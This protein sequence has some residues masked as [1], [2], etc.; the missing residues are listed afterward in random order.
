VARL[1]TRD[2]LGALPSVGSR[3]VVRPRIETPDVSAGA[4]GMAGFGKSL[5]VLGANVA[6]IADQA[7]TFEAERRFQE[8]KWNEA[9][10][11]D[12]SMR[13][14]QP[15]QAQDLPDT[16]SSGYR[17]RA[18]EFFKTI[19]D[20]LK[21][22]Y[23]AK[24][25]DAERNFYGDAATFARTEQKRFSL[26]ALDEQKNRL[27]SLGSLD[28]AVRDYD[29]LLIANP[30]LS[31]I[32]KDEVRRKHLDE[33]EELNIETRLYRGDDL[34]E[35]I[36]D[37]EAGGKPEPLKLGTIE[38]HSDGM[39]TIASGSGARFRVAGGYAERLA[40][41][42]ADLEAAGVEIKADQSGGYADRNI[43]GTRTPSQ[44]K[45]GRAIDI[46]WDENARG[47][48][49]KIDPNVAR[50]IARKW[51]LKWGGDFKN[52][53][54][55]HFE[56]DR[57]AKWDGPEEAD[58]PIGKRGLTQYAGL[59]SK[60]KASDAV[61]RADLPD[62]P[63][64]S[65]YRFLSPK[66]RAALIYKARTALSERTQQ[67]ID[68]DI[69]RLR[70]TGAVDVDEK[71]RT[72]LEKARGLLTPNQLAQKEI[73]W[74]EAQMEYSAVS[75]LPDMSE[76][77]AEE[78][79]RSLIPDADLKGESYAS[80]ARVEER[81]NREWQKIKELRKKDPAAS[82][83]GLSE[84]RSAQDKVARQAEMDA[85]DP[86]SGGTL[87][88]ENRLTPQQGKAAVIEARKAAQRRLG[89]KEYEIKPITQAEAKELLDMPE[90]SSMEPGEYVEALQRAAVRADEVYGPE[91]GYE[92]LKAAIS[93]QRRDKEE[94]EISAGILASM[95]RG[96]PVPEGE[97][98]KASELSDIDRV[99][100]VFEGPEYETERP[101]ISQQPAVVPMGSQA[102]TVAPGRAVTASPNPAQIEWLMQDP[103]A[104]ASTFDRMF[105]AGAA[106]G[107]IG[108]ASKPA[109]GKGGEGARPFA[110]PMRLG[111]PKQEADYER[112]TQ[113]QHVDPRHVYDRSTQR[114]KPFVVRPSVG[115]K[116]GPP[117]PST[118]QLDQYD[119]ERY[120]PNLLPTFDL[121]NP[122]KRPH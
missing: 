90:P 52:P 115:G 116:G 122:P 44:H 108:K 79:L 7:D 36:R 87:Y 32:E 88:A 41:A 40:G 31:P 80:A 11:L 18:K 14:V 21:P 82:V 17:E 13:Q 58:I 48:R 113:V 98:R 76:D 53:D 121:I 46:N 93:F 15:G 12:Q 73:K 9:K 33:L 84:V 25:F 118:T 78:H 61:E 59:K 109:K 56:I 100:R 104:R 111:G 10:A 120:G 72:S 26:N 74:R 16:W 62:V 51:G 114:A 35:I 106:A 19:P 102:R 43:A 34:E 89:L 30:Y 57:S 5:A 101:A 4:R 69:E 70:R 8:F 96:E 27:A 81:A 65:P 22:N 107:V 20:A 47:T 92:V 110:E 86:A 38:K 67:S 85:S 23:D 37:L 39:A 54:P 83:D 64:A 119:V 63:K 3:A 50:A 103:Q 91:Y 75:P 45:F 77:E 117:I 2:D 29:D 1:P 105:G 66:R 42:V 97:F 24:L 71:G 112:R 55:M 94:K 60:D 28:Q 95:A 68:D 49:G 6:E 99:G